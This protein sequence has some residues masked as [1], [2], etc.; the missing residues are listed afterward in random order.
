MEAASLSANS[1][2]LLVRVL[3]TGGAGFLGQYLVAQLHQGGHEV[4][5]I[6]LRPSPHSITDVSS[7]CAR[8]VYGID[9]TRPGELCE[10]FADIDV[11][12]HLAGIV[13]FWR[14]HAELL[15]RVNGEGTEQVCLA[16]RQAGV[17]RLIHIS[18]VAAVGYNERGDEP[19]DESHSFDWS[20][21]RHKHYMYSKHLA[22]LAVQRACEQGLDAVIVN[23]G[24]MWGPGDRLNSEKLIRRVLA[25]KMTACPPG[26]TNIVDVRDVAR[27]L[28]AF[29][30]KGRPGERYILGGFNL[31]FREV[32]Q[33]IADAAGVPGPARTL[34]RFSKPL[35]YW[36]AW[37]N[38]GLRRQPPPLTADNIDSAFRY[39]YFSS[40]K[41]AAEVGWQPVISFPEL[42]R[43]SI[44]WLRDRGILE[45]DSR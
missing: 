39:R 4:S 3:V 22:E 9:I 21:V 40:G 10:H 34:P 23:P 29:C 11:V 5:I 25:R 30:E 14:K 26:G 42:I 37:L 35:L 36:L 8:V 7:S 1:R 45:G 19:I 16:A 28:P 2:R 24:L 17:R 15:F 31:P 44:A 20:R 41:A 32:C 18:S 33:V 43:D 13:S 38:E 6:D 27:T 12:F